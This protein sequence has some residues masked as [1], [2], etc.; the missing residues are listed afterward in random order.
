LMGLLASLPFTIAH[1]R[2]APAD[3]HVMKFSIPL[4]ERVSFASIAISPD[5]R[6][7]AFA[8][9]PGAKEQLWVRALDAL[10]P[11][12]LPGTE[13]ASFPFWSP[14][15]RSIGFFAGAKLKKIEVS[16][17]PALTLCDAGDGRGGTWNRNGTIVFS[18][19]PT[20]VLGTDK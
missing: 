15:S 8:G 3:T 7:L 18:P 11:Q 13:G 5:G 9:G 19:S 1:L 14:N 2:Q 20:G 10:T 12:T 4:P 16:G 6:W 17:G